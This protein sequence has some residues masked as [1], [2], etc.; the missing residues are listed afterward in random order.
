VSQHVVCSIVDGGRAEQHARLGDVETA[1][2]V[3]DLACP[4]LHYDAQRSGLSLFLPCRISG[5]LAREHRQVG[6]RAGNCE[7]AAGS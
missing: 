6:C 2:D 5:R 4:R 7:H 3:L 1:Q